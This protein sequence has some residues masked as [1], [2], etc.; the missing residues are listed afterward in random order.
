MSANANNNTG[1]R[2]G[3]DVLR[4]PL[5]NK[6]SAFTE[7]QRDELG[8]RGLLPP[9]VHSQVE[10]AQRFLTN[11]RKFPDPLD[12][13]VALNSLHD[14]NESLFFHI[15]CENIDELQPIVYTPTVGLACQR[16]GQIFQ[17]PAPA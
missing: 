2:R 1:A 13:F 15:L 5:L 17:R 14:R 8:L 16:F 4:D 9:H 11:L 10:Q 7:K 6:G 3:L 12:K